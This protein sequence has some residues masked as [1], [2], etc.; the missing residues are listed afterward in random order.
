M[1]DE[2][3]KGKE[4]QVT[5]QWAGSPS[6]RVFERKDVRRLNEVDAMDFGRTWTS[7]ADTRIKA[8]LKGKVGDS[9]VLIKEDLSEVTDALDQ[10]SKT[11]NAYVVRLMKAS[12]AAT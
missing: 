7:L 2:A 3:Q 10:L 9:V 12:T 5:F 11:D 4:V 8:A 1:A 6:T